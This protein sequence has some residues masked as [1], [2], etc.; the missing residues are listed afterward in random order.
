MSTPTSAEARKALVTLAL[1]FSKTPAV[2]CDVVLMNELPRPFVGVVTAWA[3]GLGYEKPVPRRVV[4][5][6]I[7]RRPPT[8][9]FDGP[10]DGQFEQR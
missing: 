3:E 8:S 7:S 1:Y 9:Q 4:L 2:Q 6:D 10:F 5:G